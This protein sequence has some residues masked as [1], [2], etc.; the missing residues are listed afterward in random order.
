M[1]FRFPELVLRRCWPDMLLITGL[2]SL[3][4]IPSIEEDWDAMG[5]M[6]SFRNLSTI[7]ITRPFVR[8]FL[9]VFA[10]T[11]APTGT[12]E[13]DDESEPGMSFPSLRVV[14]I[15]DVVFNGEVR[16]LYHHLKAGLRRRWE[17]IDDDG[18]RLVLWRCVVPNSMLRELRKFVRELTNVPL[19]Y[20]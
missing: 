16:E 8:Q 7:T 5:S 1:R 14:E 4:L 13:L 11:G 6:V 10:E 3:R 12:S 17:D 2:R 20:D 15:R 9:R 19:E 18:I